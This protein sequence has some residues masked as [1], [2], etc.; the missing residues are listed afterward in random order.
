MRSPRGEETI[1]VPPLS[2]DKAGSENTFTLDWLAGR[3]INSRGAAIEALAA[4]PELPWKNPEELAKN[5]G[6]FTG[7]LNRSGISDEA[8]NVLTAMRHGSADP[9]QVQYILWRVY[10]VLWPSTTNP[11]VGSRNK[12]QT[13]S[14]P[15]PTPAPAQPRESM[16]R[17]HFMSTRWGGYV[18]TLPGLH[19]LDIYDAITRVLD[20][21]SHT[22][23]GRLIVRLPAS[24]DTPLAQS[25]ARHSG[26]GKTPPGE[27]EPIRALFVAPEVRTV[28]QIAINGTEAD[29]SCAITYSGLHELIKK[30]SGGAEAYARQFDFMVLLRPQDYVGNTIAPV[31]RALAAVL[32]TIAT[33]RSL[34][35]PESTRVQQLLDITP[36]QTV[37]GPSL[38]SAI[39][40]G[41]VNGVQLFAL[42]GITRSLR[43]QDTTTRLADHFGAKEL[44]PLA[45][46]T[47]RNGLVINTLSQLVTGGR[48]GLVRCMPGFM[49]GHAVRLAELAS[50]EG[51]TTLDRET[52]EL[53]PLRLRAIGSFQSTK[54]NASIEAAFCQGELDVLFFSDTPVGMDG[55]RIEFILDTA[56]ELSSD[57]K[58]QVFGLGLQ[59]KDKLTVYAE[60]FDTFTNLRTP[61]V[62]N[63][64]LVDVPEIRQGLT[65]APQANGRPST[66][67][68][69]RHSPKPVVF[70]K[71]SPAARALKPLESRI[72]AALTLETLAIEPIPT[73]WKPLAGLELPRHREGFSEVTVVA[74]V[75]QALA[76]RG[77]APKRSIDGGLWVPPDTEDIM[78][79]MSPLPLIWSGVI[80]RRLVTQWA[81]GISDDLYNKI[82]NELGIESTQG[83]D[84]YLSTRRPTSFLTPQDALRFVQHRY[85]RYPPYDEEQDCSLTEIAQA[86]GRHVSS[87]ARDIGREIEAGTIDTAL[88][89]RYIKHE[90]TCIPR[91]NKDGVLERLRV[92]PRL[93]SRERRTKLSSPRT[94]TAQPAAAIIAPRPP[95]DVADTSTEQTVPAQWE[96]VIANGLDLETIKQLR[97]YALQF[98]TPQD[99]I[100]ASLELQNTIIT[101]PYLNAEMK[102]VLGELFDTKPQDF[103]LALLGK[104]R[105]KITAS[106]GKSPLANLA[107][108]LDDWLATCLAGSS[109]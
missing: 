19:R 61:P 40:L 59:P 104:R 66:A 105:L 31:L 35:R 68:A 79:G 82:V 65:I 11:T 98:G 43:R 106:S 91:A 39:E 76:V 20:T 58:E 86:L 109:D 102:H 28:G 7:A 62:L 103:A 17:H 49:A 56:P 70:T 47:R 83:R 78:N 73:D 54:E 88:Y 67:R 52:Q 60:L 21:P 89:P 77:L 71:N 87:V 36:D 34:S 85:E 23:P 25:L 46:D 99:P 107:T 75:R 84:P 108:A 41:L 32:P 33:T 2:E 64:D 18:E 53:R 27:S 80:P 9:V 3:P 26:I 44:L 101:S 38:R 92:D 5:A 81:G 42:Q 16:S 37:S 96:Q 22:A 90:A 55:T 57:S 50:Q 97:S 4:H 8:E 95:H 45:K 10:E 12:P 51:L 15:T 48:S 30:H 100:D 24:L 14:A 93:R 6:K 74:Q 72:I 63:F 13:Q 69:P 1:I 94:K 29:A